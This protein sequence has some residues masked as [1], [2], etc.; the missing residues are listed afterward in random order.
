MA[1]TMQTV[2]KPVR[3]KRELVALI[4]AVG[5]SQASAGDWNFSPNIEIKEDFT[6]NLDLTESN[7]KSSFIT[8]VLPGFTLHKKGG[9]LDVNVDYSLQHVNYSSSQGDDTTNHQLSAATNAE[10]I[11]DNFF[12]D[13]QASMSQQRTSNRSASIGNDTNAAGST[14]DTSTFEISPYWQQRINAHTDAGARFTYNQVNFDSNGGNDSDGYDVNLFIDSKPSVSKLHWGLTAD[15]SR[16]TPDDELP[17]E[18]DEM[19]ASLGYRHSSQLDVSLS[20]GYVDNHL[21][22]TT[23]SNANAGDF[24]GVSTQWNPSARTEISASYNSRL[25]TSN[26]YGL[27]FF[28][29]T[30]SG[31]WTIN[32]SESISSA[33]EELLQSIQIGSIVCNGDRSICNA[34][35]DTNPILDDDQEI[36]TRIFELTPTLNDD[37]FI[38]KELTSNLVINK[39]KSTYNLGV[40]SRD[41]EFQSGSLNSEEDIGISLG[42]TIQ[43]NA[44]SSTTFTYDWS[45]LE[46]SGLAK[47]TEN[48]ISIH[49]DKQLSRKTTVVASISASD[50][51]SPD[52]TREFSEQS[53]GVS[54]LHNF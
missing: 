42:W 14:T 32:Y 53:L 7:E 50:R 16:A 26:D 2:S 38:S 51:S 54:L 31:S 29:R 48:T 47:D 24:W 25:Q 52:S 35:R 6:N 33:R 43:M 11:D 30:K 23:D 21:S 46:P 13:A 41:R 49:Y 3:F 1:T 17:I 10:L 28:H 22:S 36:V 19:S 8:Q 4:C 9:G 39:G 12:I 44:S 45:K 37:R 20:Y 27:N 34:V 40:Y 18:S 15:K 5:V